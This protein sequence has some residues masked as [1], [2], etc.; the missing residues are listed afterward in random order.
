MGM[1]LAR[2]REVV[3]VK[4]PEKKPAPK[5]QPKPAVKAVTK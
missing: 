5:S 1:L 3:E 2:H 4:E